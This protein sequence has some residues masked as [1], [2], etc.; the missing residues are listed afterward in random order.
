MHQRMRRA[1]ERDEHVVEVEEPAAGAGSRACRGHRAATRRAR[2]ARRRT[3][4]RRAPRE[5]PALRRQKR[6]ARSPSRTMSASG[7]KLGRGCSRRPQ[8][9][10][11]R[12]PSPARKADRPSHWPRPPPRSRSA[13][14]RGRRLAEGRR[15]VCPRPGAAA[16][17]GP[18]AEV[19]PPGGSSPPRRGRRDVGFRAKARSRSASASAGVQR[20]GH[21]DELGRMDRRRASRR[22]E[23]RE[24][25]AA[26]RLGRG[27]QLERAA[28]LAVEGGHVAR[29]AAATS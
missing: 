12:T 25:L 28:P 6:R 14:R 3:A 2:S 5:P 22:Q 4:R 11:T 21:G 23:A 19:P 18:A 1:V 15:R 24:R 16:E 17:P 8:F 29:L 10:A 27:E 9:Q 20:C 13:W 26:G 7:P